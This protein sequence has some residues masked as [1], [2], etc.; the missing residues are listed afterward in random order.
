MSEGKANAEFLKQILG[1]E[2]YEDIRE[3]VRGMADETLKGL[4]DGL[5]EK[6]VESLLDDKQAFKRITGVGSVRELV[7]Q[8]IREAAKQ[9]ARVLAA[10]TVT[11]K[12][13]V[14]HIDVNLKDMIEGKEPKE[15]EGRS[16]NSGGEE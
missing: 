14:L 11:L 6:E 10:K 4:L 13:P 5:I 9:Q 3:R 15:D 16:D 12:K 1:E 7:G 2:L 8:E